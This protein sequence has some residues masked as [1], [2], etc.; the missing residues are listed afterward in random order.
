MLKPGE[1][2]TDA[3]RQFLD[4]GITFV[5]ADLD[6]APLTQALALAL[7]EPEPGRMLLFQQPCDR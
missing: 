1:P 3:I 4:A 7:A 2:P 5:V 6:P